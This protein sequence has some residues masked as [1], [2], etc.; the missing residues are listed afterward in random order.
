MH[1]GLFDN[2]RRDVCTS[3][4][5][6]NKESMA[7][8]DS[9]SAKLPE[10]RRRVLEAVYSLGDA[11]VKEVV[12]RTGITRLTVGARLTELQQTG[13]LYKTNRT[14]EGCRVLALTTQGE[15]A[16]KGQA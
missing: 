10:L 11:T 4:H 8:F 12:E 1:P 14:R 6:G 13:M 16:V 9:L 7:A 3:H 2:P 15:R 5:H